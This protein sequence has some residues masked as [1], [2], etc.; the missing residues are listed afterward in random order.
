MKLKL[1]EN[2]GRR[3]LEAF[4]RAGHDVSSIHLQGMAGATEESVFS[5]CRNEGRV[6]VTLDLDFSNP[7]VF[8]PRPTAG[9]A[10]IRL[11]R[12][13]TP[14]ELSTA[15]ERLIAALADSSIAASR[16]VVHHD[17]IRVWSP[18]D[19]EGED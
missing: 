6:V 10:V 9:V 17:R 3:G 4:Q 2:L 1:D 19:E 18:R 15:V 5:V 16:W 8:D 14:S 13:P 11:S 12:N 7:L